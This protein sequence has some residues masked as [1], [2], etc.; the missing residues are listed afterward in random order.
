VH[1]P[2]TISDSSVQI[3]PAAL[4]F[5][6]DMACTEVV[7]DDQLSASGDARI[8]LDYMTIVPN[9]GTMFYTKSDEPDVRP[10]IAGLKRRCFLQKK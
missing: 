4:I 6:A 3:Q 9:R 2:D 8:P 10:Q 7:A 5:Y 1:L